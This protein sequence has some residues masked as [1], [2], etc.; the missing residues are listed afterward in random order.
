MFPRV[1]SLHSAGVVSSRY[2]RRAFA[3]CPKSA[4]Q[5]TRSQPLGAARACAFGLLVMGALLFSTYA[6]ATTPA[7]VTLSAAALYF[8][9]QA[10]HTTSAAQYATVANSGGSPLTVAG[11]SIAGSN[12]A[13]FNVSDY[14]GTCTTGMVLS[15]GARCILRVHFDPQ[16]SGARS[17]ALVIGDSAAGA[18]HMVSLWG[19]FT[20]GPI[21][22]PLAVAGTFYSVTLAAAGGPAP[23]T[24]SL[25]SGALP[26]GLQLNSSTGTISGTPTATGTSNF[27][28]QVTASNS[29][30]SANTAT[31]QQWITV[32]AGGGASRPIAQAPFS[33]VP[34]EFSGPFA[35]WLN[36][37]NYGAV[38]DGQHDDT[39]AIQAALSAL[40]G[41]SVAGQKAPIVLWMPAGTYLISSTLNLTAQIGV[42]MIGQDPTTTSLVWGGASGG[43]MLSLQ[44]SKWIRISRLTWNGKGVASAGHTIVWNGS[45]GYFP[46]SNL[47]S[48]EAFTGLAYGIRIGH[49]GETMVERVQFI[50][51]T[52]AGI[53]TEDQNALDVWVRDSYFNGCTV[54]VTNDAKNTPVGNGGGSF[55]VYN[56]VF[57]SSLKADMEMG[58]PLTYFSERNNFSLDSQAFFLA[59]SAGAS[60]VQAQITLQGNT[61]VDPGGT[62][63]VIGN[64]G[65]LMLI[66][67]TILLPSGATFPVVLANDPASPTDVQTMGNT[68]TGSNVLAGAW[69]YAAGSYSVGRNL[70]IG[71]TIANRQAFSV[72]APSPAPY[73]QNANRATLDV[74][75]GSS[76]AQI[77][78][79]LTLAASQGPRAVVHIPAGNYPITSTLVIAGGNDVQIIGDGAPFGTLLQWVGGGTGPLISVQDPARST[80]RDLAFDGGG[81]GAANLVQIA[82]NDVPGSRVLMSDM[83]TNNADAYGLFSD[84]LDQ[85]LTEA[86]SSRFNGTVQAVTA[87]GGISGQAG[88][89]TFGRVSSFGGED[90]GV[91]TNSYTC[92]Q[93]PGVVGGYTYAVE[94]GGQL[95]I[96][97]NWHD[98]CA[99][100]P[101]YVNLT[102]SGNLLLQG[103]MLATPA[104]PGQYPFTID[105]FKGDVSLIGF[106]FWGDLLVTGAESN[107]RFLGFGLD[108]LNTVVY[109]NSPYLLN[110]A[111]G[112]AI[113]LSMSDWYSNGVPGTPNGAVAVADQGNDS[114]SFVAAM[115]SRS[116]QI[117]PTPPLTLRTGLTD[118]RFEDIYTQNANIA[119]HLVPSNPAVS[120]VQAYALESSDLSL[121]V[122]T[123]PASTVGL[124]SSAAAAG[125]N[126]VR[127]DD[128]NFQLL[129]IANGL[130]YTAMGADLTL[131]TPGAG[132]LSQEWTFA[133]TGDGYYTI[134][135]RLS[136]L[137]L[138]IGTGSQ[139][140]TAPA[141]SKWV[142]L[143]LD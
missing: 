138:A 125:W 107:L 67:N 110:N 8:G 60:R 133:P 59:D 93:Q 50:G 46:T 127:Q 128:G 85:A 4:H 114:P 15:P 104:Q 44:G 47:E 18:P 34:E 96:E 97:D 30:V 7:Q 37:K 103:G 65:P 11:V 17:A 105:G 41:Q 29:T 112:G 48:D 101:N 84:G 64:A 83:E 12:P 19:P 16:A 54:G 91:A 124:V 39:A 140:T 71:D 120:A 95:T 70:S 89:T 28:V 42:A 10:V 68:F 132:N 129:D 27:T 79:Y 36:V 81:L 108:G 80:F 86:R 57:V 66:D 55:Q 61:I 119:F 49:A 14:A 13:D 73:R 111:M 31:Q 115:F 98:S 117:S 21:S 137:F 131:G 62:P 56:S 52:T 2:A 102:D 92:A 113:G 58:Y 20:I 26:A 74:P 53:S 43:T 135:N 9:P 87:S 106:S 130:P 33:T 100:S 22:L 118:A 6:A 24:W 121:A 94:A 99:S 63:I 88:S 122:S 141:G 23:Y 123:L 3:L 1:R 35:S 40:H 139:L 77:Q 82:V 116:R 45:S 109:P 25:A 142:V 75:P 134:R 143:P 78:A 126:L 38:G 72:Q 51:N 69:P 90:S 136:G 5:T 32:T 76:A